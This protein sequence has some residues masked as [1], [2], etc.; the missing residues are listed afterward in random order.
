MKRSLQTAF[1]AGCCIALAALL[2]APALAS[3]SKDDNRPGAVDPEDVIYSGIDLWVTPSDSRTYS[4]FSGTPIP[5]GFFCEGSAPFTGLI[6]FTGGGLESVPAGILGDADTIIHRLDDAVFDKDGVAATRVKFLALSLVSLK[7]FETECGQFSAEIRLRGEQPETSMRIER[8]D[9][10]DSGTYSAT[11]AVNAKVVFRPINGEAGKLLEIEQDVRFAPNHS[12][13]A[14]EPGYNAPAVRNY[15]Q[16]DVDGDGRAETTI[17]GPSNFH[18]GFVLQQGALT[19][20]VFQ[21]STEQLFRKN[22]Q[23]IPGGS[24]PPPPY[25]ICDEECHCDP[26]FNWDDD[27]NQVCWNTNYCKHCHCPG[28]PDPRL[29]NQTDPGQIDSGGGG[30]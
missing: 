16:V 1:R 27:P 10:P 22:V 3:S 17:P 20:A 29:V 2:A 13:W 26:R 5:A 11:L 8:Q 14:R 23:C 6:A 18:P 24:I 19:P 28:G 21:Q 7:P 9:D 30:N 15:A 25:V 4:D 12:Y